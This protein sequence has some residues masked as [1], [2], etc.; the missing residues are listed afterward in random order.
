[1]VDDPADPVV[2]ADDSGGKIG[3]RILKVDQE[4]VDRLMELVG[5]LNVAKNGLTFLAGAAEEEFGSRVLSRRIKDQYAGM[6]RI[7]EELQ[8]AV[9]DIRM[10]PLSVAFARFPRL[11]RDLGRR[12]GKSIQFVTTG[13]DTMADKDVIEALSD[14][15][16]HLIRNSIDHGIELPSERF[17][18]GKPEAA[19]VILNAR[20]DG[21]A[22]I[23]EVTDDGR[24]IDPGRVR[25]KAYE[26]GVINEEEL[27]SLTDEEA[28][29]L[30]FRPG[31]ST[32]DQI[33]DLSGRG[34]GMDAVRASVDKL[35][36]SV[37]MTSTLG[38][39]TRVVLR[40]PL[41]M[42]VTQ[43]MVVSVAGQ[44]FGI[45]VDL[46]VE[47]VR[48]PGSEV[49]RVLAQEVV[50]LRGDVVPVLDLAR[51]L[52]M[53]WTPVSGQ[54]QAVL[55][56]SVNGQRVGLRVEQFHR[57]VDVLLKPMEGLLA[58]ADEFS[59]T[60][61]LGDGLVLLVLNVKEVLSLAARVA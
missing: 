45:P 5:E 31:F 52:D 54:D 19:T 40:L 51:V 9:M 37:T 41:S 20:A 56:V 38:A 53:P 33:S 43:V 60:A 24:G 16:V 49:N 58:Y 35:G 39:G 1:V 22:V 3:A 30:V 27:E 13:E 61:L 48:V 17:N 6:H 50:V 14:P 55:V 21:D 7:A 23:V 42:A 18:A 34:V 36:G 57:E 25:R 8:S 32:A 26:K 10:L 46:V 4:K 28:L 44:R 2:R 11:V 15:L 29:D 59:G 47:T 12:L